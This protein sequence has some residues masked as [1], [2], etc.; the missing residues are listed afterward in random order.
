MADLDFLHFVALVV[1][2]GWGAYVT[3]L[4]YRKIFRDYV[5]E[6]SA[7]YRQSLDV[8]KQR[9]VRGCANDQTGTDE[10]FHERLH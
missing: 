5:N 9:Y 6:V 2:F 1:G 7:Q 10:V 3:S 8:M 4:A